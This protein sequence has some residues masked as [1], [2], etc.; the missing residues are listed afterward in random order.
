MSNGHFIEARKLLGMGLGEAALQRGDMPG[1]EVV[2]LAQVHVLMQLADHMGDIS[3]ELTR[4]REAINA[5]RL[6]PGPPR[7]APGRPGGPG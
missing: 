2:A 6:S 1:P 5:P 3:A 7:Q 4:I